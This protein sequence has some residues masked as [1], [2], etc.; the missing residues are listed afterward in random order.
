MYNL[1]LE[2]AEETD[3]ISN[4]HLVT[5]KTKEFQENNLFCFID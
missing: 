2:K 5:E 4:I 1:C 3:Q